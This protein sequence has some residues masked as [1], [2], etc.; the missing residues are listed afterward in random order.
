MNPG[1]TTLTSEV[2][3]FYC[4]ILLFIFRTNP[5]ANVKLSGKKKRLLLKEAKRLLNEK[6]QMEG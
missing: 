1:T 4:T 2:K 6:K 5:K 3:L